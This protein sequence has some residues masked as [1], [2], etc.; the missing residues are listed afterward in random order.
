[1]ALTFKDGLVEW[2]ETPPSFKMEARTQVFCA[3]C[4]EK[5]YMPEDVV[6]AEA[7]H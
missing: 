3:N 1:M 6:L 7:D 4:G 5:F 2:P